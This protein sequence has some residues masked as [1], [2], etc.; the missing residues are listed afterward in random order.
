MQVDVNSTTTVMPPLTVLLYGGGSKGV[1]P[2][3]SFFRVL[4]KPDQQ[5]AGKA[6]NVFVLVPATELPHVSRFVSTVNRRNQLKALLVSEDVDASSIPQMFVRAHLKMLRNTIVHSG[7]TIPRRLLAAWAHNA[8]D[9]LIAKATVS[10]DRLFVLSCALK[11][12]E[13]AFDEMPALKRIP[14]EEQSQFSVDEDGSYIHW[15]G[16]DTHI[17]LDA[18]RAAKDPKARARAVASKARH[19]ERYGSAI[20]KLRIAA[21]LKQSDIE[22]L[23][24]RQVRR[25]ENGEGTS[26][27][28]LEYLAAAHR[29]SLDDYLRAVAEN[30]SNS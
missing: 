28:A 14:K 30:A 13:V 20:A 25:I 17:D 9:Q 22:G 7:E 19:D 21:G 3:K 11:Q 5:S 18:I 16:S 15:P 6:R 29:M 2:D 8:Q 10:A 12:F 1:I 26:S 24:D 23:S 27:E 4:R